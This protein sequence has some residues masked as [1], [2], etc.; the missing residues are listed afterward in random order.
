MAYS[1]FYDKECRQFA[2]YRIPKQLFYDAC[3]SI[4]STDAKLL[5]GLMLDRMELSAKNLWMD[6]DGRIFIYYTL[7]EIKEIFRCSNDKAVKVINELD[8]KKGIGLI[9]VVRQ[10]QGKPNKIYVRDFIRET[11]S[12]EELRILP[13]NA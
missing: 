3:F 13:H 6:K 11:L 1:Y 10:G 4:L 5:Y 2:F 12:S 7:D 8:V 9:E